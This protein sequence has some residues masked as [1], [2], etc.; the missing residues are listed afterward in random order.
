MDNGITPVM[1]VGG[2]GYGYGDGWG[3]NGFGGIVGLLAVLGIIGGGFGNW[4]NNG[5]GYHPQYATQDFVQNGFNFND[6]QDQ[7]RDIMNLVT[8]GTAQ[9]VAATNQTYH[10]TV[11]YVG[12]K[13]D[14][15]AR[16]IYGLGVG[17]A[18]LLAKENEC[19]CQTLRAIDGVNYNAAMNTAAIQRTIVEE[20]QKNRDLFTGDRMAAMQNRIN[21]LELAQAM[22]GVV[23]YPLQTTYSSGVNPF[24]PGCNCGGM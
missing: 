18:N 6:L 3:M 1:N 22:T 15:L 24:C 4:G 10:D 14:E 21:Q 5:N 9:A 2:N 19:C 11:S 7:N 20:A 23:R 16:D 13:Y 17:Q 12:D 8:A